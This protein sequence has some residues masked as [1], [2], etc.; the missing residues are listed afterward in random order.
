MKKIVLPFWSC[1]FLVSLVVV[2]SNVIIGFPYNAGQDHWASMFLSLALVIPV[3]LIYSRL[4]KLFPDKTLPQMLQEAFGPVLG[5]I[6]NVLLMFFCFNNSCTVMFNFSS[7][8]HMSSLPKT[9]FFIVVLLFFIPVLYLLYS[10]VT[11]FGKWS[12]VIFFC[13]VL[14]MILLSM[15][16][17]DQIELSNLKP[18]L[19]HGMKDLSIGALKS[20]VFPFG[21]L[22]FSMFIIDHFDHKKSVKKFYFITLCI[23][24]TFLIVLFIRNCTLLGTETMSTILFQNYN[25]ASVIKISNFF[26]RIESLVVFFYLLGGIVRAVVSTVGFAKSLASIIS[27]PFKDL[28]IPLAF[29]CFA[30]A[31][32]PYESIM[33]VFSAT[34]ILY[35]PFGMFI[36]Y[37]VPLALWITSELKA[38]KQQP[39]APLKKIQ[40]EMEQL[41]KKAA[42][43]ESG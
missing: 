10:P 14:V 33:E 11:T 21:D 34:G 28:F 9:D 13:L 3:I 19:S 22:F 43:F 4:I 1:V 26:E 41:E 16:S 20:A 6:M 35:Y 12:G 2:S 15:F 40:I 5:R 23:T 17:F 39:S 29:F 31:L 24:F 42:A 38:K 25:A 32:T 36:E 18:V 30:C 7:F 37:V 27:I 8:V